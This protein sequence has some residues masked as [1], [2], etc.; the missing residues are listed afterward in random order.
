[1]TATPSPSA[2]A[3]PW[4][5]KDIL[6]SIVVFLVALPLSMGI[7]IASGTPVAAGLIT[8]IVGGLIAGI[9]AGCPLQVSGP[10]AGLT[11]VVYGIVAEYGLPALG[12]TVL[13]AGCVQMLAAVAGIGQWFRAVAPAVV[14]GMLS[15][16]GVLIVASQFHVMVDDR[17]SGS[18][19]R[20]LLTIPGAVATGLPLPE[21]GSTA[22]R[23]AVASL[24][25]DLGRL[26]ELQG[27][28]REGIDER[29][30]SHLSE[31]ES[32]A[33]EDWLVPLAARQASLCQQ[34]ARLVTPLLTV[35]DDGHSSKSRALAAD[36]ARV[37]AQCDAA[38]VDLRTGNIETVRAS[39]REAESALETL[40]L[41]LESDEWAAKF[42]LMTI[43]ILL[44]WEVFLAKR[45]P[46]LPG[47]L[48]AVVVA[49]VAAGLMSAPVLYVEVPEKLWTAIH[50]PQ[51]TIF[52]DVPWPRI[53]ASGLVIALVASAETLLCATAVDR[54]HSGPRTGYNREL[55]SQ[56][57]GNVICGFL[58]S[59]PMTGVIVRSAANVQA[60]ATSRLSTILHGTWILLFVSF[61]SSLL[62]TIPTS[63]LAGI[64][65]YT[66]YK[67][68]RLSTIRELMPFGKGEVFI[69]LV[70]VVVIVVEDLLIGVVLGTVLS[71]LRLLIRFTR[72]RVHI[73]P[74]ENGTTVVRLEG[75]ATFLR[76]PLLARRLD[77]IEPGATV[78][79][80]ISRL[81][82]IDHGCLELLLEWASQHQ[83]RGG[84][85]RIDWHELTRRFGHNELPILGTKSGITNGGV[86]SGET[87]RQ[88]M[89]TP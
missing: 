77:Q 78:D 21:W 46:W 24:L 38:L 15:G 52:V 63:S 50:R 68:I 61:F 57:V 14:K 75:A 71:A 54:M 81:N 89:K 43:L 42:G 8:G 44:G 36:A 82:F 55:F 7:A 70:T 18:G 5:R 86:E 11:V 65:V 27:E 88:E 23:A 32:I 66:G 4:I 51:S 12:W 56:G 58:G 76:I 67:L 62:A 6:A 60:G 19:L 40:L 73:E 25:K 64:L 85:A 48:V 1:M 10:A 16:I 3:G 30:P 35:Q 2:R 87:L 80:D 79:V 84:E 47:P 29:V 53:L 45:V 83:A 37:L 49:A 31:T 17:P 74:G 13:V 72:L 22:S 28:I 9:L 69:Y 26:H 34:L 41:D 59:L 33:E 20:N 39:Q